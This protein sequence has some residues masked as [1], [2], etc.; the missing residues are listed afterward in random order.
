MTRPERRA[1]FKAEKSI[2][3]LSHLERR[4][5]LKLKINRTTAT[6]RQT[7]NRN[8]QVRFGDIIKAMHVANK[9]HGTPLPQSLMRSQDN[10][11]KSLV[12]T[13]VLILHS[14]S[15]TRVT[16]SVAPRRWRCPTS[17]FVLETR[18]PRTLLSLTGVACIRD[19]TIVL[20]QFPLYTYVLIT[21]VKSIE[22]AQK[23][24]ASSKITAGR[25]A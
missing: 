2:V 14:Y 20:R 21:R 9:I 24:D 13:G 19:R 16:R 17:T 8:D 6:S 3:P 7:P 25:T 5:G 4:A 15:D 11:A 23:V 10:A 1:R 18:A 22:S 12:L